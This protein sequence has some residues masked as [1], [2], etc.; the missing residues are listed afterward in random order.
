MKPGKR[1]EHVSS[2]SEACSFTPDLHLDPWDKYWLRHT[3]SLQTCTDQ[4]WLVAT[5][6][7]PF[8]R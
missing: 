1:R 2:G 7:S 6:F 5:A 4:A 8:C 3:R